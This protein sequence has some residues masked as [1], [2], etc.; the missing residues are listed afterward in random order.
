MDVA[1]EGRSHR[2]G[3]S[4]TRDSNPIQAHSWEEIHSNKKA[5][6][7]SRHPSLHSKGRLGGTWKEGTEG[8]GCWPLCPGGHAGHTVFVVTFLFAKQGVRG[9]AH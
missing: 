2:S 7:D 4:E 1:K 5:L 9:P 3:A 8:P 6:G